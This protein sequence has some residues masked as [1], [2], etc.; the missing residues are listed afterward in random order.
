M[1]KLIPNVEYET[2]NGEFT[3]RLRKTQ[4]L[5][6]PRLHAVPPSKRKEMPFTPAA[7]P[8]EYDSK[9]PIDAIRCEG[10]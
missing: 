2:V 4:F 1:V 8:I 10:E 5:S 6:T 3:G 7:A 9:A